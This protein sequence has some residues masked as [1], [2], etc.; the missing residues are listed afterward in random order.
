MFLAH[1]PISYILNEK[2][3]QKGIS[4]LTKQEHIFIM[5]LSLIFGILPDLDLAILT[6]TDIPPFQHH[7]IFSHT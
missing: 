6:V 1:G 4:K 7:L 5:I 3:Q 2:I